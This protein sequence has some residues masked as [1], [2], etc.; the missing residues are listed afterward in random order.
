MRVWICFKQKTAYEMRISDWSSDVCSSD[1]DATG[2]HEESDDD[3]HGSPEHMATEE[4]NDSTDH[5]HDG[6]D[7]QD[8]C[9]VSIQKVLRHDLCSCRVRTPST[10]RPVVHPATVQN[11][12][13]IGTRRFP[14][15]GLTDRQSIVEG[16]RGSGRL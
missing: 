1:L 5:Q 14:G 2:T 13:H 8:E 12:G 10:H 11:R 7:P 4:G 6:D 9:H 3:Q 16:K 15:T